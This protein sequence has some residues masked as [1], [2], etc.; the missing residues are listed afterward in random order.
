[1]WTR[2]DG[3]LG[4]DVLREFSAVRIAFNPGVLEQ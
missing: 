2:A 3:F 4:Q 1:M